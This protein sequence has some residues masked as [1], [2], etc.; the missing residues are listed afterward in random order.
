M[1][2]FHTALALGLTPRLNGKKNYNNLESKKKFFS[3]EHLSS[4]FSNS[5]RALHNTFQ[6]TK[7]WGVIQFLG[8]SIFAFN[9]A[10]QYFLGLSK[11]KWI[12]SQSKYLGRLHDIQ[13]HYKLFFFVLG[14][15]WVFLLLPF[16]KRSL[17]GKK[18]LTV[19]LKWVFVCMPSHLFFVFF[20]SR[21]Y[22]S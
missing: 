20:L 3:W 11:L 13:I 16:A 6:K 22:I 9:R 12:T 10:P 1:T 19:R 4:C 15:V 14:S 18:S 2:V 5:W 7:P 21:V 8:N 17:R